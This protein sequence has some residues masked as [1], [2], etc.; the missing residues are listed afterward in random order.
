MA[1]KNWVEMAG[2][3]KEKEREIEV[4]QEEIAKNKTK[5]RNG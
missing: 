4:R 3:R 1:R 5:M 2:V